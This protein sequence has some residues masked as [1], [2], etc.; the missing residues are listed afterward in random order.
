MLHQEGYN[1]GGG[2]TSLD[3]PRMT[4]IGANNVHA[5]R[6][7]ERVARLQ[8]LVQFAPKLQLRVCDVYFDGFIGPQLCLPREGGNSDDQCSRPGGW[9]ESQE[10]E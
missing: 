1:S 6:A 8:E 7:D 5:I 4:H 2:Y 3:Q 10:G 9:D